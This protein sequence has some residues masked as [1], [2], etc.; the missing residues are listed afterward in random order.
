M[1]YTVTVNE[2][3]TTVST[4]DDVTTVSITESPVVISESVAGIQGATGPQGNVGA[5]GSGYG[6]TTSS[7]SNTIGTGNKNFT[8]NAINAYVSGDRVRISA[9][10]SPTSYVEGIIVVVTGTAI[11]V[12]VD[13]TNGS[14]TFTSWNVGIAGNVGATGATGPAAISYAQVLTSATTGNGT[15]LSPIFPTASDSIE[16]ANNTTYYFEA[17]VSVTK[18]AST[19]SGSWQ[20]GF[21][22]S[23]LQQNLHYQASLTSAS[24]NAATLS[25]STTS[26]STSLTLGTAGTTGATALIRYAG[27]FRTNATTGGTLT[28][29]FAQTQTPT[30]GN[31]TANTA[32]YFRLVPYSDTYPIIGGTWS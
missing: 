21:T 3:V 30:S 16:L 14:G 23:N 9:T 19:A 15:T 5:T 18:T 24:A 26:T 17:F 12:S 31:P 20:I 27:F 29:T 2:S 28:P 25:G 11:V 13:A 6:G 32:S 4:V 7:T 8:L 10:S 22:F 1:A